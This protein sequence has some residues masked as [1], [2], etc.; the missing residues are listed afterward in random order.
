MQISGVTEAKR[1]AARLWALPR[2]KFPLEQDDPPIP[3]IGIGAMERLTH[4]PTPNE[5]DRLCA[6]AS[7]FLR[8]HR[9]M[10]PYLDD[11]IA[12]VLD[13]TRK[14]P[15]KRGP[16][17]MHNYYRDFRLAYIV[18]NL[19]HRYELPRYTNNELSAQSLTA[20]GVVSEVTGCKL[21]TVIKAIQKWEGRFRALH[22]LGEE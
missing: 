21:G 19:S 3:Q 14:R 17:P 12:D 16:D 8:E 20:A 4:N 9:R 6:Y 18:E 5:H 22:Q 11:Y 13:G 7:G 15:T 2:G 1:E 10:P